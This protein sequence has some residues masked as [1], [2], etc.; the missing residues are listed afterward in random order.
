MRWL[1]RKER[2]HDLDRE[3]RSH[4]DLEAE[5]Q[6]DDGLSSEDA[7]HAAQRA[8]GNTTLVKEDVR[9]TSGWTWLETGWN[10][11]RYAARMLRK[12]PAFTAAVVLTLA[13]SIGAN[14]AIFS[15]CDAVL[16]KPL[17]YSDPDRI[18]M[19]WEQQPRGETLGSVAPVNFVDWRAQSR[20]FSE[21]AAINPF[22]NFGLTGQGE[23]A[24]LTGGAV[25][26]NF[27]SLLGT[28]IA[29]GRDFLPEEDRPGRDHVAILSYT[30]WLNRFG[31]QPD[32]LGKH[33]T[34]NDVSYSVVGV[35]PREF[36]FVGKPSDFPPRNQFEVWVPLALNPEKL[37]R[38]THPLRVFARLKPGVTLNQA[39]ADL[40]VVAANLARLYPEANK[41]KG[42]T[43]SNSCGK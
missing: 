36:E 34:L 38:G 19:L 27:F 1:R 17:P 12:N 35:L 40:N 37:Q 28:C 43:A 25:S 41:G 9:A 22:F 3:L 42:I 23:P 5:E 15:V 7:R 10:D 33:V 29:L 21:V 26:S 2:E 39:Q 16:L 24:R 6:R 20:S 31:A 13:L 8:F 4:V 30:A 14:T 18:V 11:L 32:I